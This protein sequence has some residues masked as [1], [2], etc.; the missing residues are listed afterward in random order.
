MS[1][2]RTRTVVA[3]LLAALPAFWLA[4]FLGY[5]LYDP[6]GSGMTRQWAT[7][8]G[9]L[10]AMEFLLVHAGFLSILAMVPDRLKTRLIIGG[11]L[12]AFYVLFMGMFWYVSSG[13]SVVIA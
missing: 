13:S 8:A 2:T 10:M 11:G 1:A 4:G 5:V 6:L 7:D 3:A 12:G 9:M